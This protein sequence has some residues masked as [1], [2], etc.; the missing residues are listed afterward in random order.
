MDTAALQAHI[1]ALSGV[2]NGNYSYTHSA[3]YVCYQA[4]EALAKDR[5]LQSAS[6]LKLA[7]LKTINTKL[8]CYLDVM[9]D[10]AAA[11][12]ADFAAARCVDY[13]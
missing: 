12:Y 1:T 4:L 11:K 3:D 2:G 7:L 13:R 6:A 9:K 10:V 8:I 5:A